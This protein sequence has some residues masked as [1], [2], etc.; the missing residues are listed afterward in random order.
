MIK[1][2]MLSNLTNVH[3]PLYQFNNKGFDLV[4]FILSFCYLFCSFTKKLIHFLQIYLYPI[5]TC[6]CCFKQKTL[7]FR[8]PFSLNLNINQNFMLQN[9]VPPITSIVLMM[10]MFRYF[11]WK[12]T[13][14]NIRFRII[15][16]RNV[17]IIMNVQ[18]II[19]HY[20]QPEY[21]ERFSLFSMLL[22]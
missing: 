10:M 3:F 8:K 12:N 14:N 7:H 20:Y 21:L 2:N 17:L 4:C 18:I 15:M 11:L 13:T 16:T 19:H 5:G 22:L 9:C 1:L 6:F